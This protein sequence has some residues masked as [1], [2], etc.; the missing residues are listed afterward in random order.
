MLQNP[1]NTDELRRVLR[2]MAQFSGALGLLLAARLSAA[3][4][5]I[6]LEIKCVYGCLYICLVALLAASTATVL[7]VTLSHL[8]LMACFQGLY[9]IATLG[10]ISMLAALTTYHY[11]PIRLPP[12]WW[13]SHGRGKARRR[14][15]PVMS[16]KLEGHD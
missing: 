8:I 12:N 6:C 15:V 16:G 3:L 2:T 13:Q 1:C 10:Y 5:S 14:G 9:C 4:L 7:N 11:R